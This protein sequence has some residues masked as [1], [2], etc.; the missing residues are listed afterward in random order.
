MTQAPLTMEV[1]KQ[2]FMLNQGGI[3]ILV[4]ARRLV[5]VVTA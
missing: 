5:T 4:T 1:I 3:S 2:V